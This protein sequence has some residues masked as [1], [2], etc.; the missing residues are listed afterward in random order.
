MRIPAATLLLAVCLSAGA[1][2]RSAFEAGVALYRA[3]RFA[4]AA[5]RFRA[6][7]A[8]HPEHVDGWFRLGMTLSRLEQGGEAE[9]AYR[10]AVELDP[11][12]ARGWFNLGNLRFR[13]GDY[14]EAAGLYERALAADPDYLLATYWHGWTL[15]QIHRA[16]PAEASFRRC[17]ELTPASDR[18]R[19]VQLDCRFGLGSVLHRQGDYAGSAAAMEQVLQVRPNHPEARYQLAMAYRQLGRT[20]EALVQLDYHRR[21]LDAMKKQRPIE[22]P[23]GP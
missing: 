22:A 10:R 16:E 6:A 2:D 13:A 21:L 17:L 18:D 14:T 4:E 12:L 7:T 19:A 15:R 23:D 5:E 9:A 11:D 3:K 20:D 1:E 8:A